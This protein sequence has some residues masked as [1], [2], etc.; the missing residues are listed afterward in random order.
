MNKKK[1]KDPILIGGMILLI[2]LLTLFI[3]GIMNS[4]E[5]ELPSEIQ[6]IINQLPGTIVDL[7][8]D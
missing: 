1:K 2:I 4:D 5:Q 7:I 6:E 3:I 8:D